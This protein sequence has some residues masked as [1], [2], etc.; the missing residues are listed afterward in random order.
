M[1]VKSSVFAAALGILAASVTAL[2]SQAHGPWQGSGA[3]GAQV[4]ITISCF[5]G[6]W[7]G[8]IWDRPNAVFIDSLVNAG[9]TYPEAHA[10]AERV[11][12]DHAGVGS[13][14]TMRAAMSNILAASPPGR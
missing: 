2:P 8:V 13:P 3:T 1:P 14:E 11:C 4:V 7:Q 12:R 9:Y 5:R 6:P 10:I